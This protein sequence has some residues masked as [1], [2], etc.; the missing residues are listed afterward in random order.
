MVESGTIWQAEV[1]HG[2]AATLRDGDEVDVVVVGGGI[3]GVT[4]ALLIA[5]EGRS[6][7][8]LEADRLGCGTTGAT[9]AQVTAVPDM[10]FRALLRRCGVEAGRDYLAR[11]N[12]ALEL[13]QSL[14]DSDRLACS[15]ERV[16]AY[17]FSENAAGAGR[18][19][20][21]ADAAEQLGQECRL[22]PEAPLPWPTAGALAVPR[23]ALFHPLRYLQALARVAR[24][25]GA[26]IFESTPVLA[27][28]EDR[29]GL[30]VHTANAQ[31]RAGALVL[32]THTPL[33]INPVQTELTPMQSYMLA[34]AVTQPLPAALFWDTAEPYHYLRPYQEG[35]RAMVLV[36]GADHKT[37]HEAATQEHFTQLAS[38]AHQRLH[39]A[40][41]ANWW[42]AQFYDSADG[43]PY[44]GRSPLTR[45]VYL[46]TGFAGVGL[47]Q[48]TMAA[49][50]VAAE[51][52]GEERDMPW[53]ATRLTL[54]AAPRL[55]SEG[56]DVATH[57]IG[58]RL[59][60]S[61]R[62]SVDDLAAGEGRLLRVD[63]QRRAVYRDDAGR[64]HVLSP[65]CTH[66]GCLVHWNDTSRTWDCPCHGTRYAATGEVLEGPAL[67]PLAHVETASG[68]THDRLPPVA[69]D[70][71]AQRFD[72]DKG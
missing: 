48:G 50:E 52:R 42:S 37:G 72:T 22:L 1:R 9:S 30:V 65:V 7:A 44:I 40:A 68:P 38:Y 26:Q 39:S 43:L 35:G 71:D 25:R 54:A 67:S 29:D 45:H 31:L 10:G 8:L 53:K 19:E 5:S 15:W 51:L 4:A 58:D 64:L 21:E 60:P 27:W 12:S 14:V 41:I 32:A 69:S 18:L 6:V 66:L 33:G 46:A 62:G 55:V 20:N 63:G 28:K 24:Q 61:E 16:P 34:V 11:C 36:G 49:M 47:V 56:L 17:W 70:R 59:K 2:P 57:W 3:T 23:Q 13:M